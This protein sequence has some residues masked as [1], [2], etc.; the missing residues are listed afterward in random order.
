MDILAL[1]N[2]NQA[3]KHFAPTPNKDSLFLVSEYGKTPKNIPCY[4]LR[5]HSSISCLQ[6]VVSGCGTVICDDK[7]F[8]VHSG[9]TFLLPAHTN[10]IYY[11]TTENNFSRIWINFNG[12]LADSLLDTFDLKNQIVFRQADTSVLLEEIQNACISHEDASAYEQTSALAFFKT[13]QFL[14]TFKTEN[15]ESTEQI[16]QIRLYIACH[17]VENVKIAD[18]AAKFYLSEEHLIRLFKKTYHITP[19]QY[20]LQSKLRLAM[21]M[22]RTTKDRI[23]DISNE[24]NFS[25]PRHFSSQFKKHVGIRPLAYR[26]TSLG[27]QI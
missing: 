6:Y 7:I 16:E 10:H 9:D 2:N 20:I 3:E 24:L 4:Q 8:T 26:K 25:D 18:I 27:K 21:I 14:S 5:M 23:E 11:S 1:E 15:S 19:H 13:L 17:I 12:K 22:L